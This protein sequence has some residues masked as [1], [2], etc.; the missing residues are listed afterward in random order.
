M[1]P[2]GSHGISTG[3]GTK[4]NRML[5]C[6]LVTHNAYATDSGQQDRS[7][8]PNLIVERHLYL[9]IL[10]I[11][12]YSGSQDTTCFFTRKANF[13]VAQAADIDVVGILKNANLVGGNIA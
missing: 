11:G 1:R 12:R 4:S 2:V 3:N 13:I 9:A 7:G 6:T 8:L 10:H 5:V